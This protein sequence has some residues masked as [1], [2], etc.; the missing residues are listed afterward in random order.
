MP[1]ALKSRSVFDLGLMHPRSLTHFLKDLAL[2][3]SLLLAI[4]RL[5]YISGVSLIFL[6]KLSSL[7]SIED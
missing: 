5:I 7:S 2:S 6:S 3:L 4:L 1:L